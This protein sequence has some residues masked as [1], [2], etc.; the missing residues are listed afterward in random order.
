[1][2]YLFNGIR[3]AALISLFLVFSAC[4]ES[5]PFY[6][7]KHESL[8]NK[9]YEKY[10][11]RLKTAYNDENCLGVASQLAN[12]RASK[13]L[14]YKF[15]RKAIENNPNACESI[16]RV[17]Y[18]AD[19]GFF[20]NIYK[21]DTIE[22]ERSFKMCLKKYGEKSYE[23]HVQN[24]EKEGQTRL[25]NLPQIDSTLLDKALMKSLEEI[26]KND[27]RY[28][29]KINEFNTTEEDNK[30][31]K[32][33]NKLDSLNLIKVDSILNAKGYPTSASVGN[34]L[35]DVVFIVLHHQSN[36]EIRKKYRPIIEPYL[37]GELLFIYDDRTK[38]IE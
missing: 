20:K 2:K 31:W 37:S 35:S 30:Y 32:L 19:E 18:Y 4:K 14:V 17:Q 21:L 9:Q 15:L 10:T 22:F 28:R 6:P 8:T 13:K 16:F 1:M 38:N 29:I 36:A 12:L 5:K 26:A 11:K 25:K 33:Q 34:E 23:L 3:W 7:A 24:Y 27:Q